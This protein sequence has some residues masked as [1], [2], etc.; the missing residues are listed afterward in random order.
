M[1]SVPPL[2]LVA[3]RNPGKV[4]E[5]RDILCDVPVRLVSLIDYPAVP[6]IR[7]DGAT[8]RD[9][10]FLKARGAFTA[11]GL[12]S[13]SDDSGLEVDALGGQ[14]G[15]RSA[16][17]AGEDVTYEENNV[18]LLEMLRDT[19]DERRTA[20]FVCVCAFVDGRTE[21]V[22]RGECAGRIAQSSIGGGGF[23]YDPL[24]VPEGGSE[25]FAML[26]AADKN[27]ISHR[28]RAFQKMKVFLAAH[29]TARG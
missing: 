27:D 20:R 25:S 2:L 16:R 11:T 17:F 3:T 1:A 22:E 18:K 10:A 21:H 14:P 7:E 5:I 28:G 15:V 23:G 19:P 26:S 9:N 6:D 4:K 12:P 24:F 29:F 13:L 8:L